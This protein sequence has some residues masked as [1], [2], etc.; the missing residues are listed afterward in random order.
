MK[1]SL[2]VSLAVMVGLPALAD[3]QGDGY[4]RV[5]NAK[6]KRYAYLLDNTGSMDMSTSS[7]DVNALQ[8]WSGFDEASSD[9][10]TVFKITN[11][12]NSGSASNYDIAAQGTSLY[13]FLGTYLKI[14][15]AG[16]YDGKQAYYAYASKSGFTKY[17]GDIREDLSVDKGFPSADAKGDSRKWYINPIDSNDDEGY[18]GVAPKI[19]CGGKYYQPF[20]ADFPIMAKSE[21]IKFY[22]IGRMVEGAAVLKECTGYIPA[23]TPLIIECAH[24]R[25]TDNR[26]DIKAEGAAAD[27]SGNQLKGVY[28]DNDMAT[29]YNRTPYDKATMR[30]LTC[31]DGK[32]KFVTGNYDFV[33]R[34]QAYLSVAAGTAAEVPVLT[35][36]EVEDYLQQIANERN[37]ISAIDFDPSQVKI[38]KGETFTLTPV[39][40]PANPTNPGLTWSTD[41]AAVATVADGVV[42]AVGAG[43]CHIMATSDNGVSGS[44]Q[45][46]V[47]VMPDGVTLD[48]T[49]IQL[50]SQ[51]TVQL[52]AILT[53]DDVTEKKLT[54]TTSDGDIAV[55][56]YNGVV[57]ARFP[58][59]AWI[60]VTTVNGLTAVCHVLSGSGVAEITIEG[61]AEIYDLQGNKVSSMLQGGVYIVVKDGKSH[62]V[63]VK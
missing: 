10:S 34:N 32:L 17:L 11:Y 44:A 18:F 26:L 29:H 39:L 7:A 36:D 37:K 3:L 5:Q 58:G 25:A 38:E 40:T 48:I 63:I 16:Q 33:P 49:D 13:T 50:E 22:V 8:L 51:Q 19:T 56:D 42:T 55:V 62:K 46:T 57:R 6:T 30:S 24:T 52:T 15:S 28:F 12:P 4:Y 35:E 45:V 2:L 47:T 9:P 1:K 23:G 41:N 31:V 59:E 60:T 20:Y 27:I 14:I 21:G 53:P 43:T 54:W 61:D